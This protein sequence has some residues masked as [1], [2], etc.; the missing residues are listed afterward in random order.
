MTVT[1]GELITDVGLRAQHKHGAE[2]RQTHDCTGAVKTRIAKHCGN[3]SSMSSCTRAIRLSHESNTGGSKDGNHL[4]S[5]I[6]ELRRSDFIEENQGQNDQADPRLP[7]GL[8][9]PNFHLAKHG[10]SLGWSTV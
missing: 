7:K 3:A 1:S 4:R 2:T 10:D 9:V 6:D 5:L 8:E